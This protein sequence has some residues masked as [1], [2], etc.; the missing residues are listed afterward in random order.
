MVQE[1]EHTK[2]QEQNAQDACP[3]DPAPPENSDDLQELVKK[4]SALMWRR[5]LL[6]LT[7]NA[8][9]RGRLGFSVERRTLST[10]LSFLSHLYG[11]QMVFTL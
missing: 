6:K 8:I 7:K 5:I 9:C 11:I 1:I 10:S 3:V 2:M 4:A